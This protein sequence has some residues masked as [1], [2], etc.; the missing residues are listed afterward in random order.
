MLVVQRVE[1][2]T[3]VETARVCL[4]RGDVTGQ[5]TVPLAKTRSAAVSSSLFS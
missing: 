3:S 4:S 5:L 2:T 1:V